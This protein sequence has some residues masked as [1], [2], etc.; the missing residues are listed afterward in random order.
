MGKG[1]HGNSKEHSLASKGIKTKCE[2]SNPMNTRSNKQLLFGHALTHTQKYQEDVG[3]D[4]TK[5]EHD[6]LVEKMIKRGM[7][8]NSPFKSKV[9]G[10]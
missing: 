3:V 10:N 1:W 6:R 2:V 5:C 7:N 9:G 8:H 4:N